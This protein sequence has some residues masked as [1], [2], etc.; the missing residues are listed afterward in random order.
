M[1]EIEFEIWSEGFVCSG[2][3]AK[4]MFHGKFKAETFKDAVSKWK[5]SVK[6]D[7]MRECIDTEK[8][9]CWGTRLFD[10]ESDAR[11]NFG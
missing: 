9:T 3:I 5:N 7:Y 11:K 6:D 1:E 8:L 2:G 4:A 10:N